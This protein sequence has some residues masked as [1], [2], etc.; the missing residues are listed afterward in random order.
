MNKCKSIDNFE[1]V[2]PD[3]QSDTLIFFGSLKNGQEVVMKISLIPKDTSLDNSL[4]IE[5]D[6]YKNSRCIR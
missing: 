1:F 2:P 4:L 5:Q 6:I 3:S